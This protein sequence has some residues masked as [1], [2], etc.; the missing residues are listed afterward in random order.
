MTPLW[1]KA[2]VVAAT[3]GEATGADWIANGVSIDSRT[4][5]KDDLFV[6]IKGENTDG[7]AYVAKALESGAAAAVVSDVTEAMRAAGPLVIVPD[8]LEAL[9][10]LGRAARRRTGAKIVAVTG[11]VGKTG[12]KEALRVLLS[13]QGPTHASALSYNNLW[14][15]PLSL[16]RMPGYRIRHPR[17]RHEPRG[18][19]Y[20]AEQA[21][22]AFRDAHHHGR[23]RAHGAFQFD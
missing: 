3:K 15:V 12:T 9:N 13:E 5:Q 2:E 4:V 22:R 14:G 7:H 23:G 6:A 18:R 21:R 1:T 19:N 11:S 20:T 17:N 8:A 10:E 16:A